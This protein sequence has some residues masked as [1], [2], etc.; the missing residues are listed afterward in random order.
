MTL[1][2]VSPEE[3]TIKK[4]EILGHLGKVKKSVVKVKFIVSMQMRSLQKL[5][6]NMY[7]QDCYA[8]ISILFILHK[9]IFIP[10]LRNILKH[11]FSFSIL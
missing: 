8:W 6:L 9:N 1:D 5:M 4:P 7:Y 11:L 2:G 10:I 3:R